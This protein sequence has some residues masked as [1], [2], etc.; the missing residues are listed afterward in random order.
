VTDNLQQAIAAINVGDKAIGQR[1]LVE[2]LKADEKS[3]AA[4]LWMA[5]TMDGPHRK[6]YCLKTSLEINLDSEP[7]KRGLD[8]DMSGDVGSWT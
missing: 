3:E 8:R 7:G 5:A 2:A 6:C 4:W 1:L